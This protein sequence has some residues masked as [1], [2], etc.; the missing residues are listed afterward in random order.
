MAGVTQSIAKTEQYLRLMDEVYKASAKSTDLD[1][2]ND[3]I[4]FVGGN[5]IELYKTDMDGFAN[6]SRANGFVRGG[7][8]GS[9]EALTMGQDRGIE[10]QID[11][12][13]DEE[14]LGMPLAKTLGEFVRTKEVPEVD[15]YR[16]AKYATGAGLTA[17]ADI[18]I[19]T[20]D[21]LGLIDVAQKGMNDEEVPEEGRLLF[22]SETAYAGIKKNVTRTL[23]NE[24]GV[25]REVEYLDGM[26]I[27][28]VP[29]NRFNTAITL[30]D[31][32]SN[33]GYVPTTGAYNINFM[34]I[35]PS[36][37]A[38]VVK[39]NPIK[40][41]SPSVNQDADAWKIQTRLYHDAWVLDNKTKGIYVHRAATAI[42]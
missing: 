32:S 2:A 8:E 30:Y 16:F 6:Y 12:M 36:A 20:T 35:H 9:W 31:G 18:S 4:R 33:F 3:A 10:F 37:V 41:F 38:Q 27:R 19:G 11:V 14:A 25:N 24:S 1:A 17:N 23:A 34:I 22:I 15:A 26:K 29:Q 42:S 13:D 7:V 40:I 5:K 28:R 21:V 39:H